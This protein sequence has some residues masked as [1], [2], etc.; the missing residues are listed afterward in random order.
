MYERRPLSAESL[1]SQADDFGPRMILLGAAGMLKRFG[2]VGHLAYADRFIAH[3]L[4]RHFDEAAGLLRNVPGEDLCNVG[5]GIEFVGFALDYLGA[6]A[7]A[8]LV[9][10]LERILVSSFAKG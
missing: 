9:D 5:H 6:D 8:E 2:H 4:D 3:V 10:R 7:D 1:A